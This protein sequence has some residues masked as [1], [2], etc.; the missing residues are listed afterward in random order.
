MWKITALMR[1]PLAQSGLEPVGWAQ[2][3]L[4]LVATDLTY[5][6]TDMQTE[7]NATNSIYIHMSCANKNMFGMHAFACAQKH[8]NMT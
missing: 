6:H 4:S 1:P 3:Y 2:V 5:I 7:L 8:L